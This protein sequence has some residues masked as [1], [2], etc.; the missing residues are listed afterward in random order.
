MLLLRPV[1][2]LLLFFKVISSLLKLLRAKYRYDKYNVDPRPQAVNT[3]TFRE[4]SRNVLEV[5]PIHVHGI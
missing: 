2:V 1:F 5:R 3:Y 4:L